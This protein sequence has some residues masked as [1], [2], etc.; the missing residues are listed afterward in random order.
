MSRR[1]VVRRFAVEARDQE[2]QFLAAAVAFYAFVSLVPLALVVLAV[3]TALGGERIATAAVEAAGDI[4]TPAGQNVLRDAL[5]ASEGKA[6]V[7]A[8]GVAVLL[9]SGL[10]LF[11]GLDTAFSQVYGTGDTTTLPGQLRD[12]AVA[13]GTTGGAATAVVVVGGVM[14]AL[15]LLPADLFVVLALP[16]VLFVVFLPVYY[17]FPSTDVHPGEVVPG[18]AF[19]AVG[20]TALTELFRV[21]LS[22]AG[23]FELYGVL[24]GVLLLV[25]WFYFAG[26]VIILG[27]V[28]NLVLAGR[29]TGPD[30][31][32]PA[33]DDRNP[34]A[35]APD[36]VALNHEVRA[37]R[38]RLEERTV[39]RDDLEGDLR[40]YVRSRLRRGHARGWGPYLVLLYGT[41]MTLGAFVELQG[42]WAILAMVVVWLS[43]L[44][45]YVL[46]VLAGAAVGAAGLPGRLLDRLRSL[47]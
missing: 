21:Y 44:G 13:L 10:R 18:A 4:L 46:M 8:V 43:T 45:L 9:W 16:V 27:A 37:L 26:T 31:D 19:A 23:Q 40:A 29:D 34:D 32:E 7:T 47:R 12:A 15:D 1:A 41:V 2:V 6:P 38:E 3:G 30:A 28:L 17:L 25:T 5:L 14:P 39:D 22:G 42:V 35:P 20:W 24:G 33:E 36:I 11:R